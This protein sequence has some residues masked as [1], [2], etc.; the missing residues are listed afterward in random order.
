MKMEFS[1]PL[2]SKNEGQNLAAS[3][4]KPYSIDR[5]RITSIARPFGEKKN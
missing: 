4:E 3:I 5:K 2:K 1:K